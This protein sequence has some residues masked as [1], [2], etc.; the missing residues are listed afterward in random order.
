ML[1]GNAQRGLAGDHDLEGQGTVEEV[2]DEWSGGQQMLEVVEDQERGAT[3][4]AAAMR[5]EDISPG[6]FDAEDVGDRLGDQ[7]RVSD[8]A[9]EMNQDA[10]G[11]LAATSSATRR[12]RR[13]YDAAGPGQGD[14]ADVVL[15]RRAQTADVPLP[16]DEEVSGLGSGGDSWRW[17]PTGVLLVISPSDGRES[18][19]PYTW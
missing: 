1:A 11:K 7:L 8:I 15:T 3:D 5:D 16:A 10:T 17:A 19:L 18:R 13:S 9:K 14:E 4:S 6:L 2:S 12:A